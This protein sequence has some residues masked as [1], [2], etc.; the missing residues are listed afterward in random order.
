VPMNKRENALAETVRFTIVFLT[1]Q[2]A[3][4]DDSVTDFN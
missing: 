1:E 2:R 3:R 4:E